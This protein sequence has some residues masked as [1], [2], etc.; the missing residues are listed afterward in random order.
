M[1]VMIMVV[2]AAIQVMVM[3]TVVT[4][5]VWFVVHKCFVFFVVFVSVV[6]SYVH[7]D[8]DKSIGGLRC[9]HWHLV[10]H[11]DRREPVQHRIINL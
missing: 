11:L 4:K 2:V 9:E 5:A 1:F 8:P 7:E 3:V 6:P 10:A